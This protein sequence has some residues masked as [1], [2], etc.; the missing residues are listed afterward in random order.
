MV[1]APPSAVLPHQVEAA[2][3]LSPKGYIPVMQIDDEVVRESSVL[4]ATSPRRRSHLCAMHPV[5]L[6][7]DSI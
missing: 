7:S 2:G 4:V 1:R 5:Y 3:G 6:R